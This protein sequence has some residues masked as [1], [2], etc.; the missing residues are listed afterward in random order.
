MNGYSVS[1]NFKSV[2]KSNVPTG[3]TGYLYVVDDDLIISGEDYGDPLVS[4]TVEDDC[5]VSDTFIGTTVTKKLT[6]EIYNTDNEINLENKEVQAFAG[7]DDEYVPFGT[8]IIQKP[9]DEEVKETLSAYGYDYMSK[10]DVEYEDN[11]NY[12]ITLYNF[13]KNLCSQVGLELGSVSIVNGTYEIS[14]NPFTNN[15][16]CRTVLSSIAQLAGGFARIG[17]DDKVYILNLESMPLEASSI[18]ILDG[19]NYSDDF[20]KNNEYGEI[21]SLVIELSEDIEGENT[22][23]QDANSI[24]ENGLTE[25][26]ISGNYFMTS[27]AEREKVIEGIWEVLK[28]KHYLPFSV[29]YYGYPWLDAGDNIYI[30]DSKDVSYESYVL[31]HTFTYTGSF[32]GTIE[33][34]ALTEAQTQ[35]VNTNDISTTFKRVEISVD[36]I[37][38]EITQIVEQNS[39]Y[40]EKLTQ[41]TQDIDSIKQ[42]ISN[43]TDFIH[44][45]EGVTELHLED[46]YPTEITLL[47][48]KGNITYET[49]LFPTDNL[50]PTEDL[51]PNQE[52]M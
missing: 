12:P 38:G 8:F 31:N 24:L 36:K 5:Y 49:N 35:Y 26:V 7:V 13:L 2:V 30:L 1:D 14:G 50:Y 27:E 3:L 44:K 18:D 4:F 10:F 25:V 43:T 19:N 16:T 21:N 33:T 22:A 15:E 48:I 6:L 17:R 40:E 28:G 32:S 11:N 9:D 45:V 51:Q 41:I 29:T 23:I 34:E 46:A 47:E 20:S 37:N 52:V 42:E 39:E